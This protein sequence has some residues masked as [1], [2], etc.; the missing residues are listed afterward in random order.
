[1]VWH[2]IVFGAALVVVLLGSAAV[3][4]YLQLR[5]L[6][7]LR[8]DPDMPDD[9]RSFERWRALRRLAGCALLAF[10][11]VVLTV[12]L[13]YT[14]A[15][16]EEMAQKRGQFPPDE[17]PEPTDEEKEFIREWG[18]NWVAFMLAL[19]VLVVLTAIDL[20]ANW[21][22]AVQLMRRLREER[23]AMIEEETARIREGRGP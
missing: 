6:A 7:R 15:P 2:Q 8:D 23:R 14:E 20:F 11:G 16:A 9:E 19:L 22:R 17:K 1:M 5:A 4:G 18:W 3:F 13:V 10:M 21:G 12:Q